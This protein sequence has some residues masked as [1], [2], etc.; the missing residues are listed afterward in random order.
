MVDVNNIDVP[1]VANVGFV[2]LAV[3]AGIVTTI[4]SL[5]GLAVDE[6]TLVIALKTAL[7][8]VNR[9]LAE[10]INVWSLRAILN[11]MALAGESVV[12]ADRLPATLNMAGPAS[13]SAGRDGQNP[14]QINLGFSTPPEGFKGAIFLDGVQVDISNETGDPIV[15]DIIPNVPA[16]YHTVR[17]LYRRESDGAMSRFG[18]LVT[19]LS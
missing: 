1:S 12:M 18:Q 19:I 6:R 16:G 15:W 3:E 4:K 14:T 13:V 5:A 17:V 9:P 2:A 8:D 11:Y 7:W 10:A